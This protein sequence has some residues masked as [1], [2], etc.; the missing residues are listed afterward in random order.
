[1]RPELEEATDEF[2]EMLDEWQDEALDVWRQEVRS[3]LKDE[4]ELK[5][6]AVEHVPEY[7]EETIAHTITVEY[8]D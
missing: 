7:K 5:F 1:M 3:R 8:E 4:I 2:K 6:R